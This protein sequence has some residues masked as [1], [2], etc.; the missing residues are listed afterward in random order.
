VIERSFLT[1]S[2]LQT[3]FYWH[4]AKFIWFDQTRITCKSGIRLL[5]SAKL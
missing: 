2:T 5:T 1:T 4:K 3:N